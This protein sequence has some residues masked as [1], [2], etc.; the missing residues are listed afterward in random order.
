MRGVARGIRE[1]HP[2]RRGG[3]HGNMKFGW[4]MGQGDGLYES[5]LQRIEDD[6]IE[7]NSTFHFGSEILTIASGQTD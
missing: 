2:S 1:C 6:R 4:T 3:T 7:D 5:L